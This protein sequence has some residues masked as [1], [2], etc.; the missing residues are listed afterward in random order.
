MT[1]PKPFFR[2]LSVF[3]LCLAVLTAPLQRPV[4]A[5]QATA[6]KPAAS[7]TD[8]STAL[9]AVEKALDDRRKEL[10]IPGISLAIVKDD[11]VIYLKGLGLKDVDKKLPVTP[12]T[13][14]AIG[15][16]TKAFT[17]MLAAISA[18]HGKLSLDD[19]PKKFL[20]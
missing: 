12:D 18:D 6:A 9:A 3:V 4:L 5:Q 15:S 19:S 11:Q 14:F 10:G 2:L 13:R 7:A 20:P 17:A 8:Y 1:A 16:A